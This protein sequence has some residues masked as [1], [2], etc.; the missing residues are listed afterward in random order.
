MLE[1]L[2]I[3]L[4]GVTTVALDLGELLLGRHGW[5]GPLA[6]ATLGYLPIALGA[7]GPR[8]ARAYG[9]AGGL[10]CAIAVACYFA[11][12]LPIEKLRSK[13]DEQPAVSTPRWSDTNWRRNAAPWAC[14]HG[15][16]S[17]GTHD[18]RLRAS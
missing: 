10:L 3:A 4:P 9:I 1:C 13:L 14:S 18:C 11:V 7:K 8:V 12:Q 6:L 17:D 5:V 2:D 16:G 15:W